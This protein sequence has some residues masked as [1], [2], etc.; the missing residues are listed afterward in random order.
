MVSHIRHR[1][2]EITIYGW[3]TDLRFPVDRKEI[4]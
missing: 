3:G 1:L 4:P 2:G